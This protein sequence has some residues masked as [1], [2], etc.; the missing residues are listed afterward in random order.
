MRGR[1]ELEME[2]EHAL[3]VPCP[4]CEATVGEL[5]RNVDFDTELHAP[6][7]YQRIKAADLAAANPYTP[8]QNEEP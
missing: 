8:E 1:A 5:C 6:A 2:R 7:H 3:T 4:R